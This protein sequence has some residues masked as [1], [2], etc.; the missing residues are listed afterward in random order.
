MFPKRIIIATIHLHFTVS[1]ISQ[2]KERKDS[3]VRLLGCDKLQQVDEDGA[4]FRKALGHARFE[5]NATLLLCDTALWNVNENIIKAIGHVKIIQNRTVLS[6]DKL[7][8][9]INENL[10]QFRGTLV[11]LQD[12]DKNT[13]RPRE[14]K[15]I[16]V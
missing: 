16:H 14:A 5:H 10:A 11:Q 9:L 7:D 3:L 13:L 1:R 12:K 6:S 2:R 15:T 4:S 8:Y